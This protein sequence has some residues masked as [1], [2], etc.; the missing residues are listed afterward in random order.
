[1]PA[2][3][4]GLGGY[5]SDQPH[6]FT[7]SNATVLDHS[8][9]LQ[10][11]VGV[12]VESGVVVEIGAA[13][14]GGTD[15]GGDWL[16]PGFTD[17]CSHLGL[18][19]IG[20]ESSTRDDQDKP[21]IT[22]DARASDGYNPLSA[23][24]AVTRMAGITHSV[25]CPTM[26]RL[27][28]GQAALVRTAGHT[29]Q[30]AVVR[31]PVALCVSMGRDGLGG[32]GA[33]STRIGVGRALREWMAQAPEPRSD[34][35]RGRRGRQAPSDDDSELSPADRITR[36]LRERRLKVLVTVERADDIERAL[37]WLVSTKLDGV[38]VGC[39]EGWMVADLLADAGLPVVVG[40]LMVQPDS[41]DHPHARYDNAAVLHAAGV[42]IAFGSRMN[43]MARGL[44]TDAG[45]LVAHGLPWEAAIRALTTGAAEALSIPGLGRLEPGSSASFF[46]ATG[47]P[48]QPRTRVASVWIDGRETAMRSRQTELYERF[49]TLQ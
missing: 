28:A 19:E 37:D 13:V 9:R 15:L 31:E 23:P 41:F 4:R 29:L 49:R 5:I 32:D 42:P 33:P 48:L 18:F 40:P 45:V 1:M 3:A 44:R 26:S 8:G 17:G 2:L 24:V 21:A 25:V 47:D 43:H 22:P 10:K 30:A 27:V 46:R 12:R 7:L 16:V 35:P 11:G 14:R 36:S 20:A 38:L 6:D 34:E 39:A